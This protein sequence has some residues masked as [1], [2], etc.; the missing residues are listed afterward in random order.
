M[1]TLR[2][3][4]RASDMLSGRDATTPRTLKKGRGS[5]SG[6]EASDPCSQ[7]GGHRQQTQQHVAL[8]NGQPT[9]CQLPTKNKKLCLWAPHCER[10]RRACALP[11]E[12]C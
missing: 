12:A 11:S 2:I 8:T 9:C 7:S 6:R 10:P 4:P 3:E 1:E 5:C